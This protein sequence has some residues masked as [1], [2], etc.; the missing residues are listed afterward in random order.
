MRIARVAEN[1]RPIIVVQRPLMVAV[2]RDLANAVLAKCLDRCA[3]VRPV[4]QAFPRL[5]QLRF[6]CAEIRS[7][8]ATITF[9]YLAG[10]Y[11]RIN[12]LRGPAEHDVAYWIV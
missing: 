10:H 5:F 2:A 4:H 6:Q 3:N 1:I 12:G 9:F 7:L 11:Y 8:Q